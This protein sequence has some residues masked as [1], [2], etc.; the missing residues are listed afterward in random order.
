MPYF[1]AD[2]TLAVGEVYELKGEEAL[3]AAGSRRAR[4]GETLSLQD[5]SGQRYRAVVEGGGSRGLLLRVAGAEAVPPLPARRV[6][7]LQAAVKPKALELIVQKCTEL[8]VA[9]LVFFPSAYSSIPHRELRDSKTH[10]RWERIAWEACKQSG[11]QFPPNLEIARDLTAALAESGT[12]LRRWLLESEA[13]PLQ[14]APTPIDGEH[15]LLV[16]PEGGFTAEERRQAWDAGFEGTSLG[17]LTLRAETAAV[18]ACALALFGWS[19]PS[20]A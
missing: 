8:G 7:L 1:L 12:A 16:G 18:A 3:H 2:R 20:G 5:P 9:S 13:N 15:R 6:V 14:A 4:P 17:G 11:R 19:G 10:Q